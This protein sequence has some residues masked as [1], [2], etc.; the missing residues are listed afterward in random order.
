MSTNQSSNTPAK[1]TL[2]RT[3]AITNSVLLIGITVALWYLRAQSDRNGI[4]P[5]GNLGFRTE[6]TLVS[7][8]GWYAAQRTGFHYAA[9]AAT[10]ITALAILAA[11]TA[12][13]L[14]ASQTWILIL[15]PVGWIALIIAIVIAGSHADTA[16]ISVA[17]NAASG[18]L[19]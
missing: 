2:L 15:P 7:A 4:P 6:H 5:S 18:T 9:I 13:R 17:P 19:H 1:S 3:Y 8:S 14:G 16:A 12:I 10:I 11:A